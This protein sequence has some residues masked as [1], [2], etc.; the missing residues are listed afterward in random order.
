GHRDHARGGR[1]ARRRGDGGD[2]AGAG[3]AGQRRRAG[4]ERRVCRP[5]DRGG[6]QHLRE[7]VVRGRRGRGG[8]G[9]RGGGGRAAEHGVQL[10]DAGEDAFQAHLLHTSEPG[11]GPL[12]AA[13]DGDGGELVE[14]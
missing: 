10:G 14:A 8:R 4:R 13:S 12:I 7:G 11:R 5:G 9:G 2:G 1:V 3:R 6:A